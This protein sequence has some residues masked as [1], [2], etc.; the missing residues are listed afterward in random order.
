MTV[1]G[2]FLAPGAG[3]TRD[4]PSFLAIE[5]AVA[6]LPV[7]RHDFPRRRAGRSGTDRAPVAIADIV[8]ATAA[9]AARI[10]AEADSLVLGGRS[11]GGRMCSMAVADG[12]PATGLALVSYP[13]HPPGKP[14]NL[15]VEHLPQLHVPVLFVS[16][17]R[18]PFGA[19]AEL[20]AHASVIPGPV[21]HVWLDGKGHDL[22][23]ADAAVAAAVVEWLRTL[24]ATS[25]G[26][27]RG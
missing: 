23:A 27:P 5:A 6:P 1:G 2:L 24:P 14:D 8:E 17:T 16:G 10:D 26:G 21:T 25:G 7:E 4:H 3:G 22:K 19:P 13:L 9:F 15:R 11:F 18:D 12:L 20:E